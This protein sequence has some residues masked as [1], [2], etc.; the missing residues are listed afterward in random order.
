MFFLIK[1]NKFNKLIEYKN[2]QFY[3]RHYDMNPVGKDREGFV[4][5]GSQSK[6]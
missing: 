4:S 5:G 2:D 6:K 3:S 1:R